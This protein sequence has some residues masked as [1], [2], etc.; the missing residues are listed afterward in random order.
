MTE[1]TTVV[2][3]A[4]HCV[5]TCDDLSKKL[6]RSVSKERHA[7]HQELIKDDTHGP[8]I[9]RLPVAL[10]EDDLRSDVLWGPAHLS[11]GIRWKQIK[12]EE[13]KTPE[14]RRRQEDRLQTPDKH[15]I[16]CY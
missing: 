8:P 12:T 14:E 11:D 7:A 10:A 6:L 2:L 3:L 13:E 4:P 5:L 9:H 16:V 15:F 1:Q